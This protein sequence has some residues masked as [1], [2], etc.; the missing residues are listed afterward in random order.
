MPTPTTC[1]IACGALAVDI[2]RARRL[3]LGL[4]FNFLES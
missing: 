2:R 3:G 1:V 4:E